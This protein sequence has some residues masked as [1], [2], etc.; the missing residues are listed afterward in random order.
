MFYIGML[1]VLFLQMQCCVH[2]P[3]PQRIVLQASRSRRIEHG[4]AR[5][6]Y[7]TWND[8]SLVRAIEAKNRGYSYQR[9]A[10]MYGIP[11]STLF[12]HMTGKVEIGVN[13]GPK[14]Y[15]SREEEEELASFLI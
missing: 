6:S 11:T 4:Q 9:A 1:V 7:H 12:D 8:S 3:L 13:P 15:L 10:A 2:P 14:P 5:S